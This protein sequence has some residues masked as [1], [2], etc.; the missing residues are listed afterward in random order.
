[1]LR[2]FMSENHLYIFEVKSSVADKC[3]NFY[4]VEPGSLREYIGKGT[5]CI[6]SVPTEPLLMG[7]KVYIPIDKTY[8]APKYL[9]DAYEKLPMV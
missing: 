6:F 5:T 7:D 1:M 8:S 3:G 9:R 4:L 2:T